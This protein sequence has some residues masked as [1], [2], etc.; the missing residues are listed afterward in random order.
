M[1]K[2]PQY[3]EQAKRQHVNL[4]ERE[5]AIF[6]AQGKADD[7]EA[8]SNQYTDTQ[9]ATVHQVPAGGTT[10]QVLTKINNTDYNA[11]WESLPPT[12][13]PANPT[14][15]ASD[16]AVNGSSPNF[17]RADAAP[18]IQKASSSQFGLAKV[19]GTTITAA[20][21]VISA[22]P[23]GVTKPG[24]AAI[25]SGWPVNLSGNQ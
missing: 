21:G 7:A 14:A 13:N 15:V 24:L 12:I 8:A 20:G 25:I 6:A 17:M 4:K 2:P 19:D 16:V 22:T 9:I 23:G 11:D 5:Y 1:K 18:A 10:G 3:A